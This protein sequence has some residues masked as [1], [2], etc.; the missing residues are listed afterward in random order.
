MHPRWQLWAFS[1][2]GMIWINWFI[3]NQV[4][5]FFFSSVWFW[6]FFFSPPPHSF[7][8]P[9]L[10]PP[11]L[12][13]LSDL[14]VGCERRHFVLCV[15]SL[16]LSSGSTAQLDRSASSRLPSCSR[17]DG[18]LTRGDGCSEAQCAA[19]WAV[20]AEGSRAVVDHTVFLAAQGDN[21]QREKELEPSPPPLFFLPLYSVDEKEK[22]SEKERST[23]SSSFHRDWLVEEI[24]GRDHR[25]KSAGGE[26]EKA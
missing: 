3:I 14:G 1:P 20:L 25:R 6:I 7:A 21:Q 18:A 8:F 13:K 24:R 5:P 16:W 19:V 4:L 11:F 9:P 22:G 2:P 26:E 15:S 23:S 17:Q 12:S 10:P